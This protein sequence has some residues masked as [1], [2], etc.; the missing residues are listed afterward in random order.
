MQCRDAAYR[1]IGG[2]RPGARKAG[3]APANKMPVGSVRIRTR[4]KRAGEVRAFVKVAEP[5]VW[6]ERAKVVWEAAN[7]PIPPGMVIHHI[8]RD[9]LDDSLENLEMTTRAD[10]LVEH[11]LEFEDRRAAAATAARW[12]GHVATSPKRSA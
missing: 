8:S 9:K 1:I 10:H 5:N 3:D 6:R 2:N 12:G 4:H 11:R 7:G